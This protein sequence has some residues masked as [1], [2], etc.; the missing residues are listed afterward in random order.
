VDRE[1]VDREGVG[2]SIGNVS[3]DVRR[4]LQQ[5]LSEERDLVS[6]AEHAT[7]SGEYLRLRD[8]ADELV[9]VAERRASRRVALAEALAVERAEQAQV[10]GQ[11][12]SDQAAETWR[13]LR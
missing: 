3:A 1:S 13:R 12:S 6:L 10:T 4:E 11:Q 9:K 5:L 2:M 8:L 7:V